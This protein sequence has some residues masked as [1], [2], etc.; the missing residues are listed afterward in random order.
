MLAAV[1]AVRIAVCIAVLAADS[2]VADVA[3]VQISAD[4]G[5]RPSSAQG[6]AALAPETRVPGDTGSRV[7]WVEHKGA[8]AVAAANELARCPRESFAFADATGRIAAG[9]ESLADGARPRIA[10]E[11]QSALRERW[12][13]GCGCRSGDCSLVE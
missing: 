3:A 11:T 2:P 5:G 8:A 9:W 13:I 10:S 1:A 6:V 12:V 7:R 4:R